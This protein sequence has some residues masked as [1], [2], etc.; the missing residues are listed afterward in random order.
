MKPETLKAAKAFE[1]TINEAR[2]QVTSLESTVAN[3]AVAMK[4]PGG[5]RKAW[6]VRIL[7]WSRA[8]N[9]EQDGP[10]V[11]IR[12]PIWEIH[13]QYR[14]HLIAARCRLAQAEAQLHAL[15]NE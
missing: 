4:K 14:A 6:D 13:K 15:K 9:W 3:I 12:V 10:E 11:L 2:R 8:S 5:E 7:L 1:E